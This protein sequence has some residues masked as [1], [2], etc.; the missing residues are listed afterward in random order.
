[1]VQAEQNQRH[2]LFQTECVINERSCH[3]IIDGGS[4]NNLASADMVE[5]LAL[6]TKPHLQ[7][8]YIQWLNSSSK[9]KEFADV[10]PAKV[11]PGL[12]PIRGIEHQIDLIPGASLP[13]RAPYRTN[14]EETKE[15]QRQVQELLDKGYSLS[16]CAVPVLLVPKKD[17]SWRMCVDCRAI[18][19]I[20]IRYCHPIPRLNDMLDELSGSIVFSKINLHS[21]YHQIRVKLG[22]E[23]KTAVK[24]KFGLYEWL[25]MPFGLTN[26]PS[27]FMRLG[28]AHMTNMLIICVLSL[29]PY[30]M[31]GIE[32]DEAK[33]EAI[34]SWSIPTIVTQVW[35]FLGLAG[36][37]RRF[38][39][40]FSTLAALL[41]ELTKKGAPFTW[42]A[43]HENSFNTLKDKLTHALC[44]NSQILIKPLSF[45]V[46]LVGL[47]WVLSGP[48]L[49]YSTYGKELYA[50]V[51]TL[52]T[53]QH[54]LWSREFVIHSDHESLAK[55]NRRHAKWVEF[56]ESFPYVIK[57]KK[58]NENVTA[59]ALSRR[60]TLLSQLHFRIFGLEAIKEQYAVDDDF[61]DV[62]LN[63]REG[64]FWNK[65]I[66]DDGFV[67]KANKLCISA[68]FVRLLLLQDAH[69]GGLIGHFGVKKTEDI[70]AAHFF[71]SKMRRD[72]ERFV[73]RCTTCQKAKSRLNPHGLY[74][75]LPVP[76]APWKD[77]SM[78]F[79][80]GL[81]RTKKG[82]D[83]VFVIV[84]RFSKMVRDSSVPSPVF[85]LGC[86]ERLPTLKTC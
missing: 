16:P 35:S 37:Y 33:V 78:D 15:I 19:N 57:H 43:T 74:M 14:P 72:V 45:N 63:C 10:F 30:A 67:F 9:E 12:P 39:K 69:G 3:V 36:F 65:F 62:L 60:Y 61:K 71:W 77:I 51:H 18:N 68:S 59:D 4:H 75:S 84:D 73:D 80:L 27:T 13:N 52:Q 81:P 86:D 66:R 56:I 7:P 2:T 54:Y 47:V 11:P 34:R 85:H 79:V 76:S 41:H 6:T 1:M 26:A 82:R 32:V 21:G 20:T 48:S 40:D 58:G 22:D 55:L 70:L 53:W 49:N 50:L 17:G 25:I 28:L 5:K 46:M 44:S 64:K 31:H 83:S 23:W 42:A 24:T 29:M 38:V 8:Y